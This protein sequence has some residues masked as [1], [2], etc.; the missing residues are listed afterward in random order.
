MTWRRP[1]GRAS[2]AS[3]MVFAVEA[4]ILLAAILVTVAVALV[5]SMLT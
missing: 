2:L 4:G 3:L 5:A 1:S